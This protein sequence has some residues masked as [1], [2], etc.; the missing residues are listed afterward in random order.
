VHT[1]EQLD[2]MIEVMTGIGRQ[3][4]VLQPVL[5]VVGSGR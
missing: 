4:G 3:M 5:K 2:H 1:K